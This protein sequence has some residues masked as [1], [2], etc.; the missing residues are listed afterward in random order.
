MAHT[1]SIKHSAVMRKK[2]YLHPHVA[3]YALDGADGLLETYSFQNAKNASEND[4]P[5]M[6]VKGT[7]GEWD[8]IWE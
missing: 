4:N 8:V 1:A 5:V 7:T 3:V 2:L 6:D